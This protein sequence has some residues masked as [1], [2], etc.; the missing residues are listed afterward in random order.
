MNIMRDYFI[1]L[2]IVFVFNI[3]LILFLINTL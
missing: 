1:A 3:G 2:T